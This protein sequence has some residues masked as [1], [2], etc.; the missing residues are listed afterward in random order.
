MWRYPQSY[1]VYLPFLIGALLIG[2][3][4]TAPANAGSIEEF[5]R[6]QQQQKQVNMLTGCKGYEDELEAFRKRHPTAERKPINSTMVGRI[7]TESYVQKQLTLPNG[8]MVTPVIG[9]YF[10]HP[11]YPTYWVM[12]AGPDSS[13]QRMCQRFSA[14]VNAPHFDKLVMGGDKDT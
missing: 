6:M 5:L 3:L 11:D 8:K 13:G 4:V 12:L 9:H 2:A 7:I 1:E 14:Q 10:I